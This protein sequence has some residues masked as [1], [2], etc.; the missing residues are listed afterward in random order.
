[1]DIN[2]LPTPEDAKE[3]KEYLIKDMELTSNPTATQTFSKLLNKL[4]KK[5]I[6]F[7]FWLLEYEY[8]NGFNDALDEIEEEFDDMEDGEMFDDPDEDGF[9]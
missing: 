2:Y 4:S 3:I 9:F 8:E 1:M 6:Y 5:E 7:L